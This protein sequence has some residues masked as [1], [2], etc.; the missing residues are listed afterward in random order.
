MPC[1]CRISCLGGEP[2]I[3]AGL[4]WALP[5]RLIQYVKGHLGLTKA[6]AA[7]R[8]QEVRRMCAFAAHQGSKD[9]PSLSFTGRLDPTFHL[10]A[11]SGEDWRKFQAAVCATLEHDPYAAFVRDA[12]TMG[13]YIAWCQE[14][15]NPC[16]QELQQD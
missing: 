5:D 14:Q 4:A 3:Q 16:D 10:F 8:L 7:R 12:D 13:T 15:G 6:E 1:A 2:D 11:L 9:L